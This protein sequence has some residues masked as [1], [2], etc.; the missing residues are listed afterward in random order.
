MNSED[1]WCTTSGS[2]CPSS[3]SGSHKTEMTK[4]KNV[5]KYCI[6]NREITKYQKVWSA[7]IKG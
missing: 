3:F 4:M 5:Q 2:S 6:K 7:A 1:L